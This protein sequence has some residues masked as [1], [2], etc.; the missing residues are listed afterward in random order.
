[1]KLETVTGTTF[2]VENLTCGNTTVRVHEV[3]GRLTPITLSHL[4]SSVIING[5]D[6]I[7]ALPVAEEVEE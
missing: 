4:G 5:R 3:D 2:V 6:V 7:K 1:M